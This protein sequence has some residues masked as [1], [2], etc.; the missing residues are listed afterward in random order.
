MPESADQKA[1]RIATYAFNRQRAILKT[2]ADNL[3]QA[4]DHHEESEEE[5]SPI[6]E[7]IFKDLLSESIEQHNDM[8]SLFKKLGRTPIGD[9]ELNAAGADSEAATKAFQ[10]VRNRAMLLFA[11]I[12][13]AKKEAQ[14]GGR[15]GGGGGA[16]GGAAELPKEIGRAHV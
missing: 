2:A 15:N 12:E 1:I 8:L 11:S 5:A 4:L 16:P 14:D 7:Q 3:A 13:K 10:E 9:A 6:Q